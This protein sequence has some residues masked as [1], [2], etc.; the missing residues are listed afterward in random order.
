MREKH[1]GQAGIK[2]KMLAL[3]WAVCDDA[4]VVRRKRSQPE[5]SGASISDALIWE[6]K[7]MPKYMTQKMSSG[8]LPT[9]TYYR[10]QTQDHVSHEE[11]GAFTQA[12]KSN[13]AQFN[14][15]DEAAVVEGTYKSGQGIPTG[16]GTFEI[17]RAT[18]ERPFISQGGRLDAMSLADVRPLLQAR[19]FILGDDS[20]V[21]QGIPIDAGK[22]AELKVGSFKR[23]IISCAVVMLPSSRWNFTLNGE[24]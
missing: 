18:I 11:S 6:E 1:L 13:Y 5:K 20:F 9:K 10:K 12:A 2:N 8:K 23:N 3:R 16:G 4:S 19:N 22:E 21:D 17:W 7:K 15:I 24:L 14:H